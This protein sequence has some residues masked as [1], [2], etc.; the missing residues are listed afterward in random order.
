MTNNRKIIPLITLILLLTSYTFYQQNSLIDLQDKYDTLLEENTILKETIIKL[1][2]ERDALIIKQ[3]SLFHVVAELKN[4]VLNLESINQQQKVDFIKVKKALVNLK[5]SMA[6]KAFNGDMIG[7][8]KLQ[9]ELDLLES[10]YQEQSNDI[11]KL[12]G[13]LKDLN[14]QLDDTKEESTKYKNQISKKVVEEE[15]LK[16]IKVRINGITLMDKKNREVKR[17]VKR[18]PWQIIAYDFDVLLDRHTDYLKDCSIGLEVYYPLIENKT[19]K[20]VSV[21]P[22]ERGGSK[23]NKTMLTFKI[24]DD[25]SEQTFNIKQRFVNYQNKNNK[26]FYATK[27]YLITPEGVRYKIDHFPIVINNFVVSSKRLGKR[28]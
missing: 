17:S 27:L 12:Q 6:K 10:D 18:R 28:Y 23:D 2:K 3:D 1:H 22:Y 25:S 7:S 14:N 9:S 11:I 5:K 15:V 16:N 13:K 8:A 19:A 26:G 24:K 20:E 4:E 21:Y